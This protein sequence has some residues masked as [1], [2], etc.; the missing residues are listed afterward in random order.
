VNQGDNTVSVLQTADQ[1]LV[2]TLPVGAS[3][4]WVESRADGARVYVLSHDGGTITSINSLAPVDTVIGTTPVGAG[5]ESFYYDSR[6]NRL[7]V[8]SPTTSK[9]TILDASTD[10]LPTIATIDLTAPIPSGGS[11]PCPN[12]GCSPT[13]V[14]ALPDGSRAYVASYFIDTTSANCQQTAC[15]QAQVTVI[16][17]R[18]N[19][20]TKSIPLPQ[21]SVSP[22]GNCASVRFRISATAAI[23]GSRVYVSSCDA[24]GV[25]AVNPIG[26]VYFALIPAPVSAFSPTLLTITGATQSGSE[27][28]YSYTYSQPTANTPIHL[29][30]VVTITGMSQA[31]DNGT[32]TVTGLGNGTFTV[33]NASGTSSVGENGTGIGQPPPQNP[34]F[35]LTGS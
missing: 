4:R 11:A 19:Q 3:P 30:L 27:T 21:V 14:T 25:S 8:P 9:V 33:S 2:T 28:T 15:L 12:T 31:G 22:V 7:Y 16:D 23:D 5:S 10:S 29:G 17:E 32:F 20:V 6:T 35:I 1:T 13:S 24:G 34:V 26:D 18:T